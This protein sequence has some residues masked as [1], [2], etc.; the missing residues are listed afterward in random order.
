[1]DL[2]KYQAQSVFSQQHLLCLQD[3][4]PDEILQLL[5]LAAKLTQEQK[6]GIP[7]PIL[8]GQ[9]LAMIFSKP[10][11]RTRVS[12]EVGFHQLGGHALYISANE[13]GLGQRE[14]VEDVARVF[15]RFVDGIMIRTFKQSDVEGLAKAGSIPII[16][17]LTDDFHPCQ[18]LADMLTVYEHKGQIAGLKMAF[19]GDGN[20]MAHSLMIIASKLGM[21]ITI[22]CPEGYDPQEKV[23]A[24]AKANAAQSGSK[25]E[26]EHDPM[27]GVAGA[28]IVYTDVWS[29]MGQEAETEKRRVIFAPYQVNAALMAGAKADA[30]FMHCL[31][32]HRDEEVT[33]EVIESK[34][35]VV[36]DEAENRLH[37]QKA[38]MAKLMNR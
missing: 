12:F 30:I 1:M 4:T 15:S 35:S 5:S 23:V 8:Q 28:D 33:D 32:A 3:Y 9:T 27:K 26:I 13:I 29:S 16:N 18:V 21:D 7:P 38:V 22:V 10:S 34:Q 36:F 19:V 2:L 11:A 14:S 31:P 6:L 24:W 25:G 37:A 20:N 17:G